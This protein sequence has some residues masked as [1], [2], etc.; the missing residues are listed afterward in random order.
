MTD[1]PAAPG[2]AADPTRIPA[3]SPYDRLPPVPTFTIASDDVVDGVMMNLPQVSAW[4]G[5]PGQDVSPQLSWADAPE[6]TLSYAVTMY[7]P[8][9]P[10]AAGFWHWAVANIPASVTSLPSGAGAP[11]GSLLPAGARQLVNDG[12]YAGY[13]GAAPPPGHGLHRYYVVVHAVDVETLDLGEVASPSMLGFQLFF[14]T[15]AR[16]M[17]VPVWETPAS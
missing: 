3:G 6:A 7:D 9:A 5:G 17:I 16:A 13:A 14:H 11:D 1:A 2:T 4:G 8:D 10:T 15:L 12:G